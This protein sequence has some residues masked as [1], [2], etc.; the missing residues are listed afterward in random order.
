ML[1]RLCGFGKAAF[2]RQVPAS[3]LLLHSCSCSGGAFSRGQGYIP[4]GSLAF[5]A[6]NLADIVESWVCGQACFLLHLRRHSCALCLPRHDCA[7]HTAW[8]HISASVG[9]WSPSSPCIGSCQL[10]SATLL[11]LISMPFF[12]G[13]VLFLPVPVNTVSYV[14]FNLENGCSRTWLSASR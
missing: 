5:R 6:L 14:V 10:G 11:S 3:G 13:L 2:R 8:H 4:S 9:L 7:G 12:S 1:Q